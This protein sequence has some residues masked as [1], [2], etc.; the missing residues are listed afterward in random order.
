M[1]KVKLV[2][3]IKYSYCKTIFKNIYIILSKGKW[4]W[5]KNFTIFKKLPFK[6]LKSNYFLR[7]DLKTPQWIE[8]AMYL[9]ILSMLV[10]YIHL[11]RKLKN[12]IYWHTN[13]YHYIGFWWSRIRTLEILQSIIY[14]FKPKGKFSCMTFIKNADSVICIPYTFF[15]LAYTEQFTSLSAYPHIQRI[16]NYNRC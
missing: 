6:D 10:P 12:G 9:D 8:G 15:C 7:D 1:A 16:Q 2:P 11:H 4:P 5:N 3:L 13:V 14:C